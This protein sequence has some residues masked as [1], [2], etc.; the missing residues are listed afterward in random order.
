MAGWAAAVGQ[1]PA[2]APSISQWLRKASPHDTVYVPEGEYKLPAEIRIQKPLTLLARG[3]VVLE[4]PEDQGIFRVEADSVSICGFTL[5]GVGRSYTED[6]AAIWVNGGHHFRLENNRILNSFFAIFCTRAEKGVIANNTIIGNAVDEHSSANAIHL[7]YCD[8]VTIT[9]NEVAHHRDGIYLEFTDH[10]V[11]TGNRSR[12]NLRYGL[13]FMFSNKDRYTDNVFRE[14]GAGVAVMFSDSIVMIGNQFLENWGGAAY[15]LLLKEIYDGVIRDNLFEHNTTGI[16][17]EGS[18]RVLYRANEFRDNGWALRLRGSSMDNEFTR[19]NFIGNSFDVA[20]D[21]G[22]SANRFHHNFYQAYDGYDLDRDG[23]G[24]VP[25]RPV[26]IFSYLVSE[27]EA[28]I[29]LL[30]SSFVKMLEAA[31]RLAPAVTPEL[32]TDEFPL[33]NPR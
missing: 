15:G 6:L 10:S 16:L 22:R 28:S 18:V 29:V 24:D 12:N 17:A 21:R 2:A 19:N 23:I 3:K 13:H 9:G 20:T 27:H 14:N 31:E 1:A 33:M 26:S 11:I 5:R 32:L 25:H 7:W 8:S 30:R 4:A